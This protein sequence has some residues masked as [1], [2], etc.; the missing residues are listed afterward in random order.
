MGVGQYIKG[1]VIKVYGIAYYVSKRDALSDSAFVPYADL[2]ADE[3]RQ[4]PD[5]YELLMR[6]PLD[7]TLLLQTNM[8][9]STET[10][11]SS[12]GADWKMLTD[13][14]KSTLVDSSMRSRPANERMLRVISSPDNPS[15]CSCSQVAP[16]EFNADPTCCAR[17]T[18]L[19][20]TWL[21]TGKLEVSLDMKDYKPDLMRSSSTDALSFLF[22]LLRYASMAK[23]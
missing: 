17:G 1:F 16:P 18:E 14:A 19:A 13:E 21:R 23:S 12:L 15:R 2:S 7:R 9:L 6:R 3:L 5:F 11:R 10:M 20:F 4:R 22:S 8:Q